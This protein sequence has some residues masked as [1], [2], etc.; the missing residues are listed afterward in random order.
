MVDR[1]TGRKP[2]VSLRI[3]VTDRCG[4]HCLYCRPSCAAGTAAP[5]PH[6]PGRLLNDE[7]ILSFIHAVE[8]DFSISKIH[9]TG[10]EPLLRPQLA[11][12]T[13]ALARQ[14]G[15]PMAL[16]TNGQRLAELAA[17]LKAAGL[18][19]VNVS[20]DSLT[21]Q[22]FKL[23][24]GGAS[25]ART[26][27][28]LD[29][30]LR[31]GLSPVKL[32][33]TVLRGVN[34]REIVAMAD[35]GLRRGCQV[36]FLELM[37]IGAVRGRFAELFV[38]SEEVLAALQT[39]FRLT[40]R[41]YTPGH[42]ARLFTARTTH[43]RGG[44]VGLISPYTRPFCRGCS[45]LRLTSRGEIIACLAEGKTVDVYPCLDRQSDS[46][47]QDLRECIGRLIRGKRVRGAFET[48]QT[49]VAVGG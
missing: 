21:P 16:T 42:S 14:T 13:A 28:G 8:M 12:L 11:E 37:P 47:S 20:L 1:H 24:T 17:P 41:P 40:P 7:Q 48:P 15:A 32:N 22:T 23:I 27:E 5:A 36:R 4:M 45:R 44:T 38:S 33:M 43:G 34:D 49:M 29:A 3:S 31:A 30:A 19:R 2:S 46:A 39:T 35:F 10:G 9:L 26:L 6:V 25:L 18:H